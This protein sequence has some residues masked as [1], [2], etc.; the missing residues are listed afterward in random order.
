MPNLNN[1]KLKKIKIK[2]IRQQAVEAGI[3]HSFY[4]WATHLERYG[5]YRAEDHNHGCR[6]QSPRHTGWSLGFAGTPISFRLLEPER[7]RNKYTHV[8]EKVNGIN[9]IWSRT[10]KIKYIDFRCF[11]FRIIINE[12]K[13]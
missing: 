4:S 1:Y 7:A 10:F 2:N 12:E 3:P 11:K 5:A 6:L 8:E 9:A 13:D